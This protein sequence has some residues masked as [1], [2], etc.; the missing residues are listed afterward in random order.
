[1]VIDKAVLYH[2]DA[3]KVLILN[4]LW[5]KAGISRVATLIV[6]DVAVDKAIDSS[7]G[8]ELARIKRVE[9]GIDA[10]KTGKTVPVS[11]M[12]NPLRPATSPANPRSPAFA[13]PAALDLAEIIGE[14]SLNSPLRAEQ[15]FNIVGDMLQKL[16]D[17]PELGGVGRYPETRELK[18]YNQPITLVYTVD[19]NAAVTVVAVFHTKRGLD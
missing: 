11:Q 18:F 12:F 16:Q 13:E 14:I 7:I 19:D 2:L 15:V 10:S 17:I 4:C 9:D 1:M 3:S 5:M 8:F 6:Q